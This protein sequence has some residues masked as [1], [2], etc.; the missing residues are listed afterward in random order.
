MK[1]TRGTWSRG[2]WR[3]VRPASTCRGWS[4]VC[5]AR[6]RGDWSRIRCLGG[7]TA[8]QEWT[9]P[10]LHLAGAI[11]RREDLL[12]RFHPDLRLENWRPG[13]FRLVKPAPADLLA[14]TPPNAW[15]VLALVSTGFDGEAGPRRPTV[16]LKSEGCDYRVRQLSWWQ[17]CAG[18][19]MLTVQLIPEVER[20][21]L[22][23]LPLLLPS[24]WQV[25]QVDLV[26]AN[27]P[28][29]WAVV[30]EKGR[31]ILVVDMPQALAPT[32]G[33]APPR[34][35][36]RLRSLPF[37]EP[38]AVNGKEKL[39]PALPFPDLLCLDA[40]FRQGALGISIDPAYQANAQCRQPAAVAPL[41]EKDP[42]WGRQTLDYYYAYRGLATDG[43]TGPPVAGLL[44]LQPRTPRFT[45]HC[46][47]RVL[48]TGGHPVVGIELVLRPE[49]GSPDTVDL[50]V[51]TPVVES[52]PLP[53]G[54]P[55]VV[56]A[57]SLL[58][59]RSP[60]EAVN[61]LVKPPQT[62][63]WKWQGPA[64]PGGEFKCE[65]WR[66][67]EATSCLTALA[68]HSP[69]EVAVLQAARPQ[70][71]CWR[72]F[73]TQPLREPLTL[74][75]TLNLAGQ[76]IASTGTGVP[77][78]GA[79]FA[80]WRWRVP[81]LSVPAANPM[82]GE[83]TLNA[84]GGVPLQV[85][86]S[87]GLTRA[88]A[89]GGGNPPSAW[90]TFHY[91]RPPVDLLL[92]GRVPAANPFAAE[93]VDRARLMTWVEPS[94][95]LLHHFHFQL[96]N[97]RQFALP[98]RLPPGARPLAAKVDGHWLARLE[99]SLL[100][101]G[102]T[103]LP[104]VGGPGPHQLEIFYETDLPAWKLW[105]QVEAPA[106]ELPVHPLAFRRTWCLPPGIRPLME[107]KYPCLP[108]PV[109]S[110]L[111]KAGEGVERLVPLTFSPLGL[112]LSPSSEMLDRQ[113]RLIA[114][115]GAGLRSV[116][117]SGKSWRLGELLD[118]LAF[119]Y[120]LGQAALVVD[121]SALNEARLDPAT[122]APTK[123]VSAPT[124]SLPAAPWEPFGLVVVPC[125]PAILVTTRRQFERWHAAIGGSYPISHA[126]EQ[127]VAEAALHEHDSSGRFRT[128]LDWLQRE[129]RARL[130]NSNAPAD[131]SVQGWNLAQ[132]PLLV[133]DLLGRRVD[134]VG[135][136]GRHRAGRP[137]VHRSQGSDAGLWPVPGGPAGPGRLAASPV[138]TALAAG[139]AARLS[140][141]GRP[142]HSLA[143]GPAAAPG[144]VAGTGSRL[145]RCHLVSLVGV[146]TP[147][148]AG[149]RSDSRD[150]G[151]GG[152]AVRRS[153]GT[154]GGARDQH[155]L[156]IAASRRQRSRDGP[157]PSPAAGP[158]GSVGPTRRPDCG[159]LSSPVPVMTAARPTA[160]RTSRQSF[161]SRV[162]WRKRC[163]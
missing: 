73:L 67:A 124:D 149:R 90:E 131:S 39:P 133:E 154:G 60:L 141:G 54:L 57:L 44:R 148:T 59:A 142:G 12:L 106:P 94:G 119:Q 81:L 66:P 58:A 10:A 163:R 101:P 130:D 113:R 75:T 35:T 83:V 137:P 156:S 80:R 49:I 9:S 135:A 99:P 61:L 96:R 116:Q 64:A 152:R 93:V 98:L 102:A 24:G 51:S 155:R 34:L 82:D 6:S 14:E 47:S 8:G 16:R 126:V 55:G 121:T 72:L 122:A 109:R 150:G 151:V 56:P 78:S 21:R 42:P 46:S 147:R 159:S 29:N 17:V 71:E 74:R 86:R 85:E 100:L 123:A 2:T 63:A 89:D 128:V 40:R 70:G 5:A 111:E 118:Q 138:R 157:G 22:F 136:P 19:S 162:S 108:G 103:E 161:R 104:V 112:H 115:A 1:W 68:V 33:T 45:A 87:G 84:A 144:L 30:P 7:L 13:S 69:L 50:L 160:A 20:G 107:G 31:Y 43:P 18:N 127:A 32:A 11:L 4:C 92:S 114:N 95:R 36:V 38:A 62:K 79:P 97:W 53:A 117:A 88:T 132:A 129:E 125:R 145:H 105:T 41:S 139:V 76:E 52:T 110:G 23:H 153:R 140:R 26:P 37:S 120:L 77:A 91:G 27:S 3:R 134:G 15:Q 28:P 143:A 48:F 25:D 146:G 65:R 158:A